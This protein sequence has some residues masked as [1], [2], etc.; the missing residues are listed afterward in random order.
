MAVVKFTPQK[1][2]NKADVI[3]WAN[4]ANG[5]TGS[6]YTAVVRPDKTF[7]IFVGGNKFRKN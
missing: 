4:L 2:D 3:T 5:D 1:F 7:Q 6:N